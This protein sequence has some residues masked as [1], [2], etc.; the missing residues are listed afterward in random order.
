VAGPGVDWL[1]L[2]P[3]PLAGPG[4]EQDADRLAREGRRRIGR[5]HR[6]VPGGQG[7]VAGRGGPLSR[8]QF[9]AGLAPGAEGAVQDA[10]V[11]YPCP[12]QQPPG[13]GGGETAVVVV[14]D[15]R[16]PVTQPPCTGR[17]LQGR[18][19][20]QRMAPGL[21]A[22][23]GGE[24]GVEGAVNGRWD[25]PLKVVVTA[26]RVAQYPADV[27]DQRPVV[28]VQQLAQPRRVD[29]HSVSHGELPC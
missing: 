13:A 4:V 18:D 21:A 7:D 12:A 3:V 27:E 24:L 26:V 2:A 9:V 25:V 10:D 29:E 20:R 5:Q 8:L 22:G 6:Q 19:V 16:L 1:G 15:D 28:T 14:D 23:R 17:R 11:R